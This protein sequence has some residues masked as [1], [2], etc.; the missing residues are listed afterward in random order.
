[1]RHP[2][3]VIVICDGNRPDFISDATTPEM[4]A[5]KRTGTWFDNHRGIF[6]SATRASSAAIATGSYPLHHG[7]RGNSVGLPIPGGHEFHDAGK[8]EFYDTYRR[9][10][11]RMLTRPALAERVA[12][13]NGAIISANVSPGAAFFHDSYGHGHMFHR[14]LCYGPGRIPTGE[15]ITSPSGAEGD[16][17]MTE[18]FLTALDGM[19]P[20]TATLWL[21]EPDKSMHAAPLGSDI[22]L[23][24]LR[25]ADLLVGR[26]AQAVERLRDDGHDVL[27]MVGSDHGH[28]AVTEVIPVERRL[29]QA[30][31]KKELES[32]EV[33]VTPQGGS[34]FIHFGGDALARRDEAA[35]WLR[36]QPWVREVFMGEYLASLGQIPSDDILAIDMA[37]TEGTNING[38]PGLSAMAVR[39][40]ETED[41]IRQ[42]CGVHGGR[43]AFETRPVLM[44]TGRGFSGG[45]TVTD[46]TS[47]VDIAPTAMAHLG[48]AIEQVDGRALQGR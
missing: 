14:E 9:H 27:F 10:F 19:R 42:H 24:A 37:K 15:Q 16:A 44:A 1:M 13:L 48:L 6:P 31:F 29:F 2:M 39:F 43:G 23:D 28:E 4:A 34:A 35:H 26:V 41:D 5:L 47:I 22:H 45:R 7:L 38:V 32:P 8:P 33:I 30:G 3:V 40:S 18:R 25:G 12:G 21:S 20:S 36:E 46:T 17:I 11:G